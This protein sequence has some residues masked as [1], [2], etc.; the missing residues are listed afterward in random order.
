MPFQRCGW[1][2]LSD[3]STCATPLAVAVVVASLTATTLFLLSLSAVLI[4]IGR[5]DFSAV[6]IRDLTLTSARL[7]S[8]DFVVA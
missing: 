7:A 4:L 6:L 1:L 8:A 5:S 3:C 2:T